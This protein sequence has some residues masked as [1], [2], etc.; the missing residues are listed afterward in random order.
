MHEQNVTPAATYDAR[1][2]AKLLRIKE[3]T[4]RARAGAYIAAGM[5]KPLPL[6]GIRRWSAAAVRAWL[7]SNGGQSEPTITTEIDLVA[8]AREALEAR[9]EGRAA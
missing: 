5:P 2:M 7:K 6:P 8:Q 1:D 4:F 9:I 3:R